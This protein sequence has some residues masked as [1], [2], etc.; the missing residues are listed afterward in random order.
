[1]TAPARAIRARL[2]A[3][4]RGLANVAWRP[5][6]GGDAL[7]R[8]LAGAQAFI[9]TAEED[10]GIA[11]VESQA[12]GTPVI[13]FGK[14]GARNIVMTGAHPTGV[15]FSEQTPD[16]LMAAVERFERLR[17]APAT[18]RENAGRFSQERFRRG[19]GQAVEQALLRRTYHED[20]FT[21]YREAG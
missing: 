5:Q 7:A 21:P 9:H 14:G 19:F 2:Q 18:C 20:G 6:L 3:L 8:A 1:M 17:I 15:L 12:S 13:A 16:A 11:L 4:C 10:F